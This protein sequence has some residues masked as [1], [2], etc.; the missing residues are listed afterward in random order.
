MSKTPNGISTT[1]AE[2]FATTSVSF[3]LE[4]VSA[5]FDLDGTLPYQVEHGWAASCNAMALKIAHEA[6]LGDHALMSDSLAD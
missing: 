1:S 2:N 6:S 5:G 4:A 3:S